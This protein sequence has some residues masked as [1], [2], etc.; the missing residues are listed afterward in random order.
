MSNTK[1]DDITGTIGRTPVVRINRLAPIS[2]SLFVNPCD[3]YP[4]HFIRYHLK[5]YKYAYY[6]GHR[7]AYW[8]SIF[9]PYN[10]PVHI[11]PVRIY[12]ATV[13]KTSITPCDYCSSYSITY[14]F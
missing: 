2:V 10:L 8:Y 4:T 7:R 11:Y 12:S 9:G 3:Y 1:F 13:R 14:D 6:Q 5:N